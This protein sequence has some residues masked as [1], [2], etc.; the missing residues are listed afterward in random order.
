MKAQNCKVLIKFEINFA[1]PC[2]ADDKDNIYNA[3]SQLLV[4]CKLSYITEI[5]LMHEQELFAIFYNDG[6][7]SFKRCCRI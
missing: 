7:G 6:N 4:K 1:P 2:T 5:G 3:V